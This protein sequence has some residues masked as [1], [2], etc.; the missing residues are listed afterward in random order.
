VAIKH[1][2]PPLS[3]LLPLLEATVSVVLP[4]MLPEAAAIFVDPAATVLAR[5]LL[6]IVA[7]DVLD[8]LQVTFVVISWLFSSEHAPKPTNC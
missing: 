5:P 4:D 2:P 8:E 6:L 1:P 7:T 3:P